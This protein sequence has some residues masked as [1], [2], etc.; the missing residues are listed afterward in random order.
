M[1]QEPPEEQASPLPTTRRA[2]VLTAGNV[3]NMKLETQPMPAP[4]DGEVLVAVEAIGLNFAD[5]FS[6]LGLYGATP[7][8][9]FTPGL[10][11][12]GS[13]VSARGDVPFRP[14]DRVM[15]CTRFGAYADY[16]VSPAALLRPIP[17][18]WSVAQGAACLV[19]ALTMYYALV[20]LGG[21]RAGHAVMVHSLAGGC[22]QWAAKICRHVGAVVSGTVGSEAKK[23]GLLEQLPWLQPWQVVVRETPREFGAQLDGVLSQAGAEG[24][25]VVL[26]AVL[27]GWMQPGFDRVAKGGRYVVYGAADMTPKGGKPGWIRLAWQYL[28]R[29]R[30]D[31]LALPG[32]NRSVMGFNL[33]W[34]FDKVD[35]LGRMVDELLAMDLAPA[36][37]GVTMP[38]E[39]APAAI[40]KLQSGQTT[41]KVVLTVRREG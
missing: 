39:D 6:V 25:D 16:V 31:P 37:I 41:G 19:Q 21:L 27:G 15:G 7:E 29:P 28:T 1:S 8:G 2:W 18:S 9:A 40:A 30:I 4:G 13:V 33:I 24:F 12:A 35:E 38:F 23:A 20:A 11:F 10:E 34:M 17:D 32:Q 3:A 5:V 26:D 22:G 36:E 14:G